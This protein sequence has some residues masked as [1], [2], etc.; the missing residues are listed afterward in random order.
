V[1]IVR[2]RIAPELK[3]FT[4][5]SEGSNDNVTCPLPFFVSDDSNGDEVFVF[6]L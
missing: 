1:A 5:W 4:G 6:N 2:R 3:E